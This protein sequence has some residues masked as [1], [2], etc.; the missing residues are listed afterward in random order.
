MKKII[1]ALFAVSWGFTWG[2]YGRGQEEPSLVQT[3]RPFRVGEQWYDCTLDLRNGEIEVV[4]CDP[5]LP[6]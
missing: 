3:E 6:D 5:D 1:A 4:Q 2:W